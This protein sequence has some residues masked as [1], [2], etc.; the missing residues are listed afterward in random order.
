MGNLLNP[1]Y[2]NQAIAYNNVEF[3]YDNLIDDLILRIKD[4]KTTSYSAH[5]MSNKMAYL[6]TED[7]YIVGY[8]FCHFSELFLPIILQI[9]L[10]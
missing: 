9:G 10:V 7:D 2:I 1:K 5:F 3:I 6:I 8:Q 4:I